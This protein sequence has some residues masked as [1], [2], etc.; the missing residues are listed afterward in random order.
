MGSK[1]PRGMFCRLTATAA[2]VLILLIG[3]QSIDSKVGEQR[4]AELR[5]K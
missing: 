5:K 1:R 4:V 3:I 2:V